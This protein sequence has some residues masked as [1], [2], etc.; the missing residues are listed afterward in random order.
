MRLQEGRRYFDRT[1]VEGMV[2]EL[3]ASIAREPRPSLFLLGHYAMKEKQPFVQALALIAI[4][5]RYAKK[6][7]VYFANRFNTSD[8]PVLS[9]V[10]TQIITGRYQ[11]T[12]LKD[13]YRPKYLKPLMEK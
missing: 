1:Y 5:E 8:H 9:H 11:V 2:D 13:K 10:C 6:Y 3:Q 4:R 7:A 12:S